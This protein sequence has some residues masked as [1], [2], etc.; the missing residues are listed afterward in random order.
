MKVVK[1]TRKK[2]EKMHKELLKNLT[3]SPRL[4][5]YMTEEDRME[6]MDLQDMCVTIDL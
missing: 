6:L 4:H 1:I 2:F 3:V 5:P